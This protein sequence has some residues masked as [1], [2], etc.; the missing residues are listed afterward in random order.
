MRWTTDVDKANQR[1]VTRRKVESRVGFFAGNGRIRSTILLDP[2][3][4]WTRI[5]ESGTQIVNRL[6]AVQFHDC[7]MMQRGTFVQKP[8]LSESG[9]DDIGRGELEVFAGHAN[10]VRLSPEGYVS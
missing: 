4:R 7:Q 1:I 8:E 2:R 3:R 10:D 9:G 5:R 6:A